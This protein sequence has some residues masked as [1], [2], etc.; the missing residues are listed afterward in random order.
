VNYE[1]VALQE[2]E[3]EE[4]EEKYPSVVDLNIANTLNT[5]STLHNTHAHTYTYVHTMYDVSRAGELFIP[6]G[7]TIAAT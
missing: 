6:S 1:R 7:V 5:F 4:E 3:E 2:E